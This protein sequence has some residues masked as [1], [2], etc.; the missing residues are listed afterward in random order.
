M[1]SNKFPKSCIF[2]GNKP[3]EKT[4]EHIIPQW[5]IKLTGDPNREVN[6]GISSK[7]VSGKR[8][9]AIRKY[10]FS[11]FHF[12]ACKKCN[13][14]F[15]KLEDKAK[16]IIEKIL[17]KGFHNNK[18]ISTLLD[19]LDKVRTGLWLGGL[20]L[21]QDMSPIRPNF[22]IKDRIAE[23]DRCLFVYE[24]ND[25]WKGIQFWGTN[26]PIFSFTPSCFSLCI[27]N[28]FFLNI[29]TDFLFSRNIGFPFAEKKTFRK[30]DNY[31]LITMSPGLEKIKLPLV[32]FNYLKPSIELY[33]PIISKKLL[34]NGKD[35]DDL[36]KS[37]FIKSNCLDYSKGNG[38]I[39]YIE[40]NKLIKLENDYEICL[41]IESLKY[42]RET[43][44]TTHS[45]QIIDIQHFMTKDL[46]TVDNLPS[47]RRKTARDTFKTLI[48][49]QKAYRGLI[50]NGSS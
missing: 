11:A 8:E 22:H 18:D 42:D 4:K 46:P 5:L 10:A 37:D 40:S 33:Q 43:F 7:I 47:E 48:K 36:Y 23:K 44:L 19:W 28:Y 6:L 50:K 39:F 27:N 24:M 41:S 1:H 21:D 49:L 35:I 14:E 32:K 2:C 30:Q 20:I 26:L 29:S 17:Q 34:L 3:E 25:D 16:E 13:T 38:D 45:K 12:P 9:F 15:S 31:T